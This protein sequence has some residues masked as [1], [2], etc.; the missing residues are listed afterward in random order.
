MEYYPINSNNKMGYHI[1]DQ[2]FIW[3][4][5]MHAND[6]LNIAEEENKKRLEEQKNNSFVGRLNREREMYN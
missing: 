2:S 4:G 5:Y 1:I 3:I 6:Q